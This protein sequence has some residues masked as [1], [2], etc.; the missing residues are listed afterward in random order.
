[1]AIKITLE[2]IEPTQLIKPLKAAPH[3]PPYKIHK[4]FARR[5]WNVFDQL[6]R[7]VSEEGEL[8]LDPFCGGGVTVYEGVKAGRRVIGI[9]VNPLA[10][11]IVKNMLKTSKDRDE[12]ESVL[13]S[14]RSYLENLYNDFYTFSKGKEN[15]Q[16]NWCELAYEVECNSCGEKNLLLNSSKISPGVYRCSNRLCPSNSLDKL[17]FRPHQTKRCGYKYVYLVNKS[18]KSK[19]IKEIN[20]LDQ[21]ILEKHLAFLREEVKKN[22]INIHQHKIPDLWDRQ[23]EDLLSQKGIIHFED[24]F[25]ERNLL[26]NTLLRWK[27]DQVASKISTSNYELIRL[28]HSNILKETNVMSFTNDTWQGGNPTTWSKHAYWLPSQFCETSLLSAF[29]NSV[30]RIQKSLDF[31]D[32]SLKSSV[33]VNHTFDS[34]NIPDVTLITGTLAGA[35][36]PPE[37]VDAIVTDPPYGSNVQY[38]ELSHF[39]YHWNKDLYTDQAMFSVEAVANRKNYSGSKTMHDYELLLFDVFKEA[40]QV[41][42]TDRYM[43]LTF[44]NKNVTAWLGLLISIF[45]AGFSFERNGLIFQDGVANY[46]QTAHTKYVGSPFGDFIYVFKKGTTTRNIHQIDSE[47]QFISK[48][49]GIFKKNLARGESGDKNSIK[50]DLFLEAMPYI[51]DY[52]KM[53]LV[54]VSNHQLYDYF[55]KSYFNGLYK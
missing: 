46:R 40:F 38:L 2:R 53:N 26:L 42:K 35:K 23:F 48:I 18:G 45:R 30:K 29:D 19:T 3:T 20:S 11:F 12:L 44:N 50:R 55:T 52:V 27:I 34:A 39:W 36:L 6:I 21:E 4:Y 25:T 14:C 43:V 49:D 1:M 7:A 24:F 28:I 33:S 16:I 8:V 13:L 37:S 32:H 22:K 10:T 41:L 5:P 9:D 47:D 17:G 31:N 15:Y 51:E 54:E